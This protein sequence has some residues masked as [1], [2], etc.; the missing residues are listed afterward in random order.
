ILSSTAE[1]V[2]FLLG[3][4]RSGTT[5]LATMLDRHPAIAAPPE[6]WLMIALDQFGHVPCAHP[7]NAGVLAPAINDPLTA[8]V[9][10]S[11]SA[12]FARTVYASLA[13]ARGKSHFVGKTP[14]YY[15]VLPTL[16]AVFPAARHVVLLRNALDIAA[17]MRLAWNIDIASLI[18]R[19]ADDPFVFDL[20]FGLEQLPAFSQA[21]PCR[22]SN[23][24]LH[25]TVF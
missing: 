16:D 25:P 11:A 9:R 1:D 23:R 8:P 10:S 21:Y 12:A 2:S 18:A 5:L 17:S 13:A 3:V 7:A 14:R 6:P 15:H 22:V 24:C 4:P 20:V 19:Q